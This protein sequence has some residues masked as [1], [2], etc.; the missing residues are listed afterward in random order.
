MNNPFNVR[1]NKFL[2]KSYSESVNTLEGT[3]EVGNTYQDLMGFGELWVIT[4]I[5]FEEIYLVS[6]SNQFRPTIVI[7]YDEGFT[8]RF[9]RHLVTKED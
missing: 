4:K 1:I 6:I 2:I 7:G 3:V 8:F 9:S 5:E